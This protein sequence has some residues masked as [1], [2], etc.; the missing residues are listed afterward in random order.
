M[1]SFLSPLHPQEAFMLTFLIPLTPRSVLFDNP[2]KT[3]Y[4]SLHFLL[5]DTFN[6]AAGVSK[7]SFLTSLPPRYLSCSLSPKARRKS[8]SFLFYIL[9]F[10]FLT[11]L[12]PQEPFSSPFSHPQK[13][14]CSLFSP[15]YPHSSLYVLFSHLSTPQKSLCS[16]FLPL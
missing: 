13:S 15:L 3:M 6:H 7:F 8:Y 10:S 12:P 9:L 5:S 11:S 14:V 16:L 2:N 4:R 1:L